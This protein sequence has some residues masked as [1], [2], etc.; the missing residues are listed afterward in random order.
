MNRS[1]KIKVDIESVN[2]MAEADA[3]ELVQKSEE[4]YIAGVCKTAKYLESHRRYK[5]A[6]ISGPSGSGKTTTAMKLAEELEEI[7]M[8]AVTVSLDNFFKNREDVPLLPNRRND[9]ESINTVD[10][11]CFNRCISKLLET[12]HAKFP[13]FNFV[14]GVREEDVIDIKSN[15]DSVII[16]EGIHALNPVITKGHSDDFLK[17]YVCPEEEFYN[18]KERVLSSRNLRLIRRTI[19]DHKFRGSSAEN[20]FNMWVE[21]CVGEEKNVIPYKPEADIVLNTVHL[22]EPLIYSDYLLPILKE[23]GEKSEFYPKAQELIVILSQ[24]SK[25]SPEQIPNDS[26]LREFIG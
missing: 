18:G 26:M 25:L 16:I 2:K 14:K 21:V 8:H 1:K 20:T 6:L 7:G 13:L 15:G 24:F 10:V 17:L 11:D 19:R 9:Y 22:Y 3:A 4:D 12:K 5:V 23:I